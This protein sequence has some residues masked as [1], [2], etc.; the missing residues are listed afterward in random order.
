MMS[1]KSNYLLVKLNMKKQRQSETER[2]AEESSRENSKCCR[3]T[4]P[5]KASMHKSNECS[6]S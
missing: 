2:H 1:T 4:A 6:V 5:T 3:Q